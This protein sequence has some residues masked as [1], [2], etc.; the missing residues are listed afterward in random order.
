MT[1]IWIAFAV[2]AVFVLGIAIRS[3]DETIVLPPE[4]KARTSPDIEPSF[5]ER[6]PRLPPVPFDERETAFFGKWR[7]ARY[8]G[9]RVAFLSVDKGVQI[10]AGDFDADVEQLSDVYLSQVGDARPLPRKGSPQR[11]AVA[12]GP[13][14]AELDDRFF[15][16]ATGGSYAALRRQRVRR[17]L[18]DLSDSIAEVSF[19]ESGGVELWTDASAT[20]ESVAAD[21]EVAVAL[22]RALVD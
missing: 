17:A 2:G 6:D 14:G 9:C 22:H 7:E 5:G 16:N 3:R 11:L 21:V 12:L 1:E 15:L 18:S 10:I 8:R 13:E 20:R 19:L 4:S